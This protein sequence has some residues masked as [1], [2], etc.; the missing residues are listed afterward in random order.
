[1]YSTLAG[2]AYG[3]ASVGGSDTGGQLGFIALPMGWEVAPDDTD[4]RIVIAKH[5]WSA[6]YVVVSGGS[7]YPTSDTSMPIPTP[8][9]LL[10][11]ASM[12]FFKPKSNNTHVLIRK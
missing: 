4:S 1:M 12:R 10:S 8:G 6:V 9:E 2:I 7:R 11:D 5:A 3:E